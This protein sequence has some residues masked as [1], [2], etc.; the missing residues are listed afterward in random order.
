MKMKTAEGVT[1]AILIT[2]VVLLNLFHHT[3]FYAVTM[4]ILGIGFFLFCLIFA[5][6]NKRGKLF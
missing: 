6:L 1:L 2:L 5:I 3:P 4:L